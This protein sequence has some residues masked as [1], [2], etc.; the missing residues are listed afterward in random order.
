MLLASLFAKAQTA[1]VGYMPQDGAFSIASSVGG[2]YSSVYDSYLSHNR[3]SGFNI[4]CSFEAVHHRKD[5]LFFDLFESECLINLSELKDEARYSYS[6]AVGLDALFKLNYAFF[7]KGNISLYTGPGLAT[8][9]G[10]VY[11]PSNSNNPAQVK[12][13]CMFAP[14]VA[15]VWR[16]KVVDYPMALRVKTTI[17]LLGITFAPQYGQLYYEMYKYDGYTK[18][19][20]FAWPFKMPVIYND[21]ALDFPVAGSLLR[22]SYNH[23]YSFCQ[24]SN[25]T[26]AMNNHAFMIGVVRTLKELPYAK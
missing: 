1:R 13:H 14:H 4:T 24:Y 19:I 18:T 7:E 22:L 8:R 9:L 6:Y 10:A 26:S 15:G 3:Y 23:N 16:F 17:P 20:R 2:G 5:A 12:F 11:N 21:I 25:N